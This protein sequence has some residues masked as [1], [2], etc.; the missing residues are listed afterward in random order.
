MDNKYYTIK[1]IELITGYDEEDIL[2]IIK[3]INEEVKK[4]YSS[5][6]VQPLLFDRMIEKKYFLRGM[7]NLIWERC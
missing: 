2:V 7:E 4:K 1:D 3:K 6:Q 5:S